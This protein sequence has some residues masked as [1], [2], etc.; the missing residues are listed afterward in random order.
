VADLFADA[1][2]EG[3]V[4]VLRTELPLRAGAVR[5]YQAV[6]G[7]ILIM[8]FMQAV[9]ATG[10]VTPAVVMQEQ[11]LPVTQTVKQATAPVSYREET[12]NSGQL[13]L[14]LALS[15]E[16]GEPVLLAKPVPESPLFGGSQSMRHYDIHS[17]AK[18]FC[19]GT[20]T[21]TADFA[22]AKQLYA[23]AIKNEIGRR[24][25]QRAAV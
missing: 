25:L 5:G 13:R 10:Q 19:S 2:S 9:A 23:S 1:P 15:V 6:L 3:I 14:R 24:D 11:L 8:L 22:A 20:L 7:I 17:A 4:M 12:L 21:P 18:F 16:L